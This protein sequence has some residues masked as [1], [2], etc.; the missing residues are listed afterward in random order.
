MSFTFARVLEAQRLLSE[1]KVEAAAAVLLPAA[2]QDPK[3]PNAASLLS[4]IL[5]RLRRYPQ[6]LHY[7]QRA[8][9]IVPTDAGYLANLALMN[10]S[11][12]KHAES[13]RF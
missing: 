8:S 12:G 1:D 5:F 11:V 4:I 3:E 10:A 7:A 9:A 6:A 2:Q 13:Q